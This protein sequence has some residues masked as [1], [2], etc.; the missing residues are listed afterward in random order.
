M[1][2][3]NGHTAKGEGEMVALYPRVSSLELRDEG[4]ISI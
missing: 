1:P 4:T 3:A 2:S